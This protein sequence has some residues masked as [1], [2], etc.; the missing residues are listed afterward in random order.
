MDALAAQLRQWA[1]GIGHELRF[2]QGWLGTR[3]GGWPQDFAQRVTP[4]QPLPPILAR[5]LRGRRGPV[6][7]LDVGAGPLSS[8][9]TVLPGAEVE[10]IATDPLAA[11]YAEL[12]GA[13]GV[14]P[15]VPTR[16]ALAEELEAFFPRDHFDLVHCRN[17][18][19]H[20]FDPLR[21]IAQMLGVLRP[22]GHVVLLHHRNEAERER[23]DGFHQWNFD[24]REGRFVIWNRAVELDVGTLLATPH[25]MTPRLGGMVEVVIEKTGSTPEALRT[26]H[27]AR[28][29][30]WLAAFVAELAS[31][32]PCN[33]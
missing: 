29:A 31:R 30:A 22:G 26:D 20:S 24:I 25:R 33:P 28:L 17:A 12:C 4:D 32:Q 14:V 10:L 1:G 15:P 7:V 21:G 18:L 9:G 16:F 6:R 2:W 8:L 19:D 3:G 11:L 23:Y 5:L 13:A 27:A